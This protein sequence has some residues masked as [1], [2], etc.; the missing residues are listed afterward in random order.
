MRRFKS[1]ADA[2]RFLSIF[3]VINDLFKVGRHIL[4]AELSRLPLARRLTAW[5]EVAGVAPAAT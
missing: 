5:R 3:G 2:Q 1:M 4:K